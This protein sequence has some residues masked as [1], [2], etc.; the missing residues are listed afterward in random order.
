[1]NVIG[2]DLSLTAPGMAAPGRKP[3]TLRTDAKR[4]DQRFC[5]IRDWLVY[6]IEPL[7]WAQRRVDLAMIEAVPPYD[8][9]SSVLSLVH[10]VAR[11]VLARYDVPL[12]YVNV[13]ALKSFA[14]G[15]G[16]ADKARVMAY[17]RERTGRM[18]DDD[19]QAD[20]FVLRDM[21]EMF[22]SDWPALGGPF[23]QPMSGIEWPLRVGDPGWPQPYGPLRQKPVRKKCG[24]KILA[25]KNG[26][27]WLHPFNVVSCDKPPK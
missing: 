25:L 21:G 3:E 11:E 16:R 22:A 24:H 20:A 15:D 12:A 2:L 7:R 6:N 8:H 23:V 13:T 5:D 18:P 10:G 14:T 26:D 17:V 1:M 27:G 19:N 4:G 9:A